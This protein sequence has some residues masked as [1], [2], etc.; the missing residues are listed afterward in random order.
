VAACV[1]ARA[2]ATCTDVLPAAGCRGTEVLTAQT[3][4]HGGDM[5]MSVCCASVCVCMCTLQSK[6]TCCNTLNRRKSVLSG[7]RSDWY[8][9]LHSCRCSVTVGNG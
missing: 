3:C 2:E 1:I 7:C 4:V 6:K 5:A 9:D 8:D